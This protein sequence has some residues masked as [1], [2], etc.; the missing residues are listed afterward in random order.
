M[1]RKIILCLLLTGIF[2]AGYAAD[3][4]PSAE[5]QVYFSPHGGC[6]DAIVSA[7]NDAKKTVLVQAYSFTSAPIAKALIEAHRR[8]VDVRVILDKTNRTRNY[9]VADLLLH[10][11][12]PTWIDI[13]HTI[14]HS[15]VIIID[16]GTVITGS[17]N[18]TKAA[19]DHNTEN[20]LV[21]HDPGLA[22]KYTENW[23][24]CQKQA[25]PYGGK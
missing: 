11:G 9:S 10:E 21:I 15:K 8:G 16:G 14:A 22:R 1:F 23:D 3:S 18:F 25:E 6:T 2:T 19:E 4:V 7:V 13:V 24:I 20:L 17:F 5:I 12:V